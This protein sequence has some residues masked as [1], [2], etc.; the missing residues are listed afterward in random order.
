[1]KKGTLIS[2]G[3]GAWGVVASIQDLGT[4]WSSAEMRLKK[5]STDWTWFELELSFDALKG[6]KVKKGIVLKTSKPITIAELHL[7]F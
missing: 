7:N 4:S 2:L 1:M 6:R 5:R 3:N